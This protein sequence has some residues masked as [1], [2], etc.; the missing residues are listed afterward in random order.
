MNFT[1]R[2]N[3]TVVKVLSHWER[4]E[5]RVKTGYAGCRGNS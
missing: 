4:I 3:S 2:G 1:C 5:V